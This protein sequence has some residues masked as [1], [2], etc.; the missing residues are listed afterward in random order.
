MGKSKWKT[1]KTEGHVEVF[2]VPKSLYD[3]L[4]DE[5]VTLK[6]LKD[7]IF[8][9]T[10]VVHEGNAALIDMVEKVRG[11]NNESAKKFWADRLEAM[12]KVL[13]LNSHMRDRLVTLEIQYSNLYDKYYEMLDYCKALQEKLSK[14]ENLDNE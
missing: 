1:P 10:S 8:N 9:S 2:K 7:D 6:M 14:Y 12:M 5:S 4:N 13:G 11:T 3:K